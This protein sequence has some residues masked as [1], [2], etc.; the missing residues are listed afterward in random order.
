MMSSDRK[1]RDFG[2]YYYIYIYV[3]LKHNIVVK[4]KVN[5]N[6]RKPAKTM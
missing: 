6:A 5:E 2:D 1:T 3:L 4:K